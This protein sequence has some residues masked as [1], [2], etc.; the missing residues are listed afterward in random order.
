VIGPLALLVV[1]GVLLGEP[2]TVVPSPALPP[3][4]TP[5]ASNN[6]CAI[7]MVEG[8]L[9][10]AFRTAPVHFASPRARMYVVS[11]ADLGRTWAFEMVVAGGADAREPCFISIGGKLIFQW[12]DAGTDALAFE[13][14]RLRR[15]V[16]L[17]AARWTEPEEFGEPGEV[18]W[19]VKVRGGRAYRTSY[20]GNHY[21]VDKASVEVR[22]QTSTDG[23]S[24]AP[25]DPEHPV[26]YRGGI[27]EVAFEF[28]A[29]GALLAMGRNEDGDATGFGSMVAT[30]P[31]NALGRW[32]WPARSD[33]ERYDSP[34]MFRHGVDIYLVARRDVGGP[35][36]RGARA[37]VRPPA[38]LQPGRLL[39]AA[40]AHGPL[41]HGGPPPRPRRRS[42][43]GRGHGLR[44]GHRARR[45]EVPRRELHVAALGSRS[46]VDARADLDGGHVDLL[47]RDRLRGVGVG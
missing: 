13:P 42:A 27:S 47:A 17:G 23:L 7:E 39:A 1:L 24:W 36:D 20:H 37:A 14:R 28:D 4:V 21:A 46:L 32:T 38:D 12:F 26:V 45:G 30:A 35:F 33:P 34:E 25:V 11:S 15:C 22:F 6:N 41:P 5:M 31:A 9:F 2:R 29:A 8:R 3:E 44:V 10:L 43:V 18:V 19:D 40:E 16:R